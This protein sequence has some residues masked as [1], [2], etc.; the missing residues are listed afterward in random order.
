MRS[1]QILIIGGGPAG[2]F[3]AISA[4]KQDPSATVT[5]LTRETCEPYEKP[6]LSKA[7]LVGRAAPEDAPIAGPNGIAGHGV[8]LE[9]CADCAAIDRGSHSVVLADGRRVG[10][11]ALVIATGCLP[12]ELPQLP[13]GAPRVHYLRTDTDA[14]ALEAALRE[15]GS[16]LVIGG[17]LIGLEVAASATERGVK[18]TVLEAAPRILSRV[19]D[20]GTGAAVHAAHAQRGVDIRVSTM[21]ATSS[22]TAAGHIAAVT[23]NGDRL[24]ADLVVVGTGSKPDTR[25]AAAAGLAVDDGIVVDANCRTSD[26]AIFAAGDCVRFPGPDGLVRLENW[27]HAIDQGTV[28]GRNAAED[29][30]GDNVEYS[31]VPSFWSEQYDLYIQGVGWQAAG[32]ARV[33]RRLTSGMLAF[34]VLEGRVVSAMG[35]N[36]Q[37]DLAMARRLIERGVP[38]ESGALADPNRPLGG[39]LKNR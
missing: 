17:G 14:R 25:L 22:A 2:V 24:V 20:E 32:A 29:P 10:Y 18:V 38:V 28:A 3:A 34:D 23:A 21:L 36:V 19:C 6:P 27:R 13:V 15:T 35:I 37:R 8:H 39:M 5:L 4:K 11:D 16:L 1:R 31:T 30:P 7:V 33:N 9:T 26:P 12:C